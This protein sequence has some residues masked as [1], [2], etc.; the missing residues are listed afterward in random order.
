MNVVSV[1]NTHICV[2]DRLSRLGV[3]DKNLYRFIRVDGDAPGQYDQEHRQKRY[4]S[5]GEM[6]RRHRVLGKPV[7]RSE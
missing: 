6:Q 3:H 2:W 1:P 5:Y 7:R 4:S